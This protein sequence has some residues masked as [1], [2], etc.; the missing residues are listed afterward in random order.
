VEGGGEL[1]KTFMWLQP[2][3]FC[4]CWVSIYLTQQLPFGQ[5][6]LDWVRAAGAA[7]GPFVNPGHASLLLF[8]SNKVPAKTCGLAA[9]NVARLT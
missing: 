6:H 2:P 3:F 1:A 5:T 9:N 8:K 4:N 7:L